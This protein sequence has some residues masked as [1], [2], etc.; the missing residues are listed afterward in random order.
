MIGEIPQPTKP[1][2]NKL[3]ETTQY[4]KDLAKW[5]TI[6]DSL[7]GANRSTV[8]VDPMSRL[9]GLSNCSFMW[10]KFQ[11]LYRNAGFLKRDAIF[12]RPSTK[13]LEDFQRV[14]E[15]ANAI[16]KDAKRLKVIGITD[17]PSWIYATWLL[18]GLSSGCDGFKTMLNN[19][20][21]AT[22]SEGR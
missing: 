13:T 20:Q 7:E 1:A 15:F 6:W 22:E 3:E 11:L 12:I 2:E 5:N 16:K 10:K 8:T 14:A 17:L 18:H 21:R 4:E 19:N 9:H